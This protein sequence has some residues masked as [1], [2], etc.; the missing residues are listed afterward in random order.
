MASCVPEEMTGPDHISK[1]PGQIPWTVSAVEVLASEVSSGP[2]ALSFTCKFRLE[3]QGGRRP[4]EG[5]DGG[6]GGER[7]RGR[8]NASKAF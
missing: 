8:E 6:S 4:G 3:N 7:E 5:G 2:F 1:N